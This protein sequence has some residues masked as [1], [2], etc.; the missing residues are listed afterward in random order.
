MCHLSTSAAA[1]KRL[2]SSDLLCSWLQQL[3][4][5][6]CGHLPVDAALHQ[7]AMLCVKG[8]LLD[9]ESAARPA[10][11]AAAAAVTVA[12]MSYI[13]LI[14]HYSSTSLPFCVS[15]VSCLMQKPRLVLQQHQD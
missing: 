4:L 2:R 8:Q 14:Q 11:A 6:F 3:L 15:K 12:E 10:A 1:I 9:G 7:L 5:L 13:T